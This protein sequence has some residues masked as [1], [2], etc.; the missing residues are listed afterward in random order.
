[1]INTRR[2]DN[3]LLKSNINTSELVFLLKL[4]IFNREI[5]Y[6]RNVTFFLYKHSHLDESQL[7]LNRQNI[8]TIFF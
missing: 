3:I 4:S 2:S 5:I 1:M 8:M 7:N 6:L